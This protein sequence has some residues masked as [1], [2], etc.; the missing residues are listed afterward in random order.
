MGNSGPQTWNSSPRGGHGLPSPVSHIPEK[1]GLPSRVRGVGAV[2]PGFP[3][4]PIGTSAVGYL[5]HCAPSGGDA[6]RKKPAATT[7]TNADD[8][9]REAMV[10]SENAVDDNLER[11]AELPAASGSAGLQACQ[12]R[13]GSPE[14]LPYT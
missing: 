6:H 5:N 13:P 14:G 4:A 10:L 1:S 3:S 2:R 12:R 11:V 8:V 9:K 7:A